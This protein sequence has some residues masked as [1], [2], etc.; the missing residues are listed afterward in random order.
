MRAHPPVTTPEV[1]W[2]QGG[3]R[4]QH[5]LTTYMGYL[6]YHHQTVKLFDN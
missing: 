3:D 5:F 2:L 1:T 6:M 4:L